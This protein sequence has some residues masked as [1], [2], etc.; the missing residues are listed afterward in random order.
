MA[1]RADQALVARGLA[2]SRSAA[3]RLIADGAV[4][5]AQGPILRKPSHLVS[6][7]DDLQV[8]ASDETRFVSRAGAKLDHAL[9]HF[10]IDPAGLEVLDLG[11]ST[12]GFTDCLLQRGASRVVGIEVGHGQLHERLRRDPRVVCIERTNLR[13]LD[14]E[15]LQILQRQHTSLA[16]Q[17]SLQAS[18]PQSTGLPCGGLKPRFCMAVADLSFISLAKVL[19]AINRLLEPQ[20]CVLMLVKPQFELGPSALDSKGIVKSESLAR[21]AVDLIAQSASEL[22]WQVLGCTES[23]V[24]GTDGNLEFFL[25]ARTRESG[26]AQGS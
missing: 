2:S 16:M 3:Q 12:G 7:L 10:G 20:A 8:D 11:Q 5:L 9:T 17:D 4:R 15:M 22:G 1:M 25:N 23:V 6:E 13:D 19:P 24:R 26:N 14:L 18:V 21:T